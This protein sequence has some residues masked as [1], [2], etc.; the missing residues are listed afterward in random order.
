MSENHYLYLILRALMILI[1]LS[2]KKG[3]DNLD[4]DLDAVMKLTEIENELLRAEEVA[5]HD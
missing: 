4:A 3:E 5:P 2:I 1:E